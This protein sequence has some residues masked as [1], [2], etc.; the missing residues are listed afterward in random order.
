MHSHRAEASSWHA[1][2]LTY[3][4]HTADCI[5]DIERLRLYKTGFHRN[6]ARDRTDADFDAEHQGPLLGIRNIAGIAKEL[7]R[8]HCIEPLISV[9]SKSQMTAIGRSST[10]PQ[11][12]RTRQGRRQS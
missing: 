11:V 8:R 5:D 12:S 1:L 6:L 10:Y 9:L 2:R 7:W 4:R 3:L